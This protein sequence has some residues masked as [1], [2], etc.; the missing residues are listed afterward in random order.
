M[1]AS[2]LFDDFVA[3]AYVQVVGVGQLHLGFD[4]FQ[5]L[6]GYGSLDGSHGSHIHEHGGLYGSV[7]GFKFSSFCSSFLFQQ[8][9]HSFSPL[10]FHGRRLPPGLPQSGAGSNCS[11]IRLLLSEYGEGRM[12]WL[13]LL[14][15]T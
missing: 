15:D 11:D 7:Y 12:L 14:S 5:I 1:E 10:F 13:I 6:C 3:G 2:Q 8:T 9:V 4:L